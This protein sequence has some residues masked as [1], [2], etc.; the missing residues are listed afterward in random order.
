MFNVEA[1]KAAEVSR[2]LASPEGRY[3]IGQTM[4]EPFR[5]GRDYVSIGRKIFAVDHVQPGAPMWYDKDPQ[6]SAYTIAKYGGAR[7][8]EVKGTRV[9]LESFPIA[10]LVRIP[11]LEVAVRRFNILDREQVRA[12]AEMAEQ[13]DVEVLAALGA[14]V[15]ASAAKTAS[16]SAFPVTAQSCASTTVA[17]T[18]LANLFAQIEQY[19]ANVENLLFHAKDYKDIRGWTGTDFDPVTRRE[20]LKTGYM[21]DLWGASIRISKKVTVGQMIACAAPEFLGVMSVRIDL[22]Q[23][24]APMGEL[25]Q[26][27]W[28]FYQYLGVAQLTDVGACTL[29]VTR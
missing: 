1:Q 14:G 12:R 13:E 8:V 18:D 9:E 19:D 17:R 2:A 23:M 24:D 16:D 28:V 21:G 22:D 29:T 25:L 26:Y 3:E 7:R 15:T 27:G 4:L 20:L 5:E 11:V 10:V 6:F